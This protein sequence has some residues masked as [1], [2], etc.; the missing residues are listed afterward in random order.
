MATNVLYNL[1]L[2]IWLSFSHTYL[3]DN[4]Q[5]VCMLRESLACVRTQRLIK[6]YQMALCS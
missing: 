1:K 4:R 5:Q 6:K 3:S 2:G